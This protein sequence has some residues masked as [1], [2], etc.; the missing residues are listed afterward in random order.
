[1]TDVWDLIGAGA[2]IVHTLATNVSLGAY[3]YINV[4]E[5]PARL[6]LPSS[7][8]MLEHFQAT[9][10]RARDKMKPLWLLATLSGISGTTLH[11][12]CL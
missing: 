11:Y 4:V 12:S 2:R 3:L 7:E 10:P 8:A 9:F 6:S 1:M 5:T